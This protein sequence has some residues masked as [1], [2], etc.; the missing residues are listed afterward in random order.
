VLPALADRLDRAFPEFGWKRDSRG[1]VATNEEMTHRVLGARAERVVAHGPAPRGFLVHGGDAILWTAYLNSGFVPRGEAFASIVRQIAERAGV[2]TSP[3]DRPRPRDRRADLFES[4]ATLCRTE[5]RGNAGA[6]ARAYLEGRGLPTGAIDHS[7]LGVVPREL[8]TKNALEAAGYSELE[9]AQ[10]G[11]LA[12]GRWP[13]R[14]CGAWRDERGQTRT[15]W[16]RSLKDSDSSTRYLYLTGASRS[17]L[18]PYGLS[19]V[20]RLPPSERS[21]LLLVEGLIDVHHLRAKGLP[22]VA[23]VGGARLNSNLIPRIGR[24]GFDTI[25][26]AFDNDAP[27]REGVF[28]AVEGVSRLKEAP[29][30]RV[31]E[32]KQLGDS[33]DPDAFVRE[34]GTEK[35][36]DLIEQADCAISWR[37]LELTRGVTP[38]DD[39]SLRRAALARAGNWLGTLPPRLSL[40]QEDAVRRVADQCGYSRTAVERA[41]RERF[42]N[43]SPA[44]SQRRERGFVIE[45]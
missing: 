20:Q 18:P 14:L 42:W 4:F 30:L 38:Q 9:V 12:D 35:F 17:G 8:F 25:V 3:I 19:D 28:R 7:G 29:T 21:E 26:L 23:A 31:L 2:E 41:F 1:W 13:G 44:L 16:A 33:K 24:L 34:H 10:S 37:A 11:V 40:E 36:R 39:T 6:R 15:L 43:R 45:R 5:L 22:N 32:P 27:G